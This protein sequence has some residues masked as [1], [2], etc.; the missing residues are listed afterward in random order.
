MELHARAEFEFERP[1][2]DP[3]PR[4]RQQRLQAQGLGIAIQQR[5]E[6]LMRDDQAGAGVVEVGI[7]VGQRVTP[8]DAQRVGGF[9]R[10]GREGAEAEQRQLSLRGAQR[11]GNPQHDAG[12]R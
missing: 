1:V 8:D 3:L 2:V 7:D 10:L 11:R 4:L 12:T 6:R 9:L 5:V